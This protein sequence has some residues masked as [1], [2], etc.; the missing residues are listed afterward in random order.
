LDG[1]EVGDPAD[2]MAALGGERVGRPV[3]LRLLRGGEPRT[4]AVTVGERP[5][6]R[7]K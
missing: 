5:A 1:H 4:I 2:L 6:R 3:E 7:G